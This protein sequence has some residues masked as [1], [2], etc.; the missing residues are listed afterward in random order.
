MLISIGVVAI[1]LLA[2]PSAPPVI[3]RRGFNN[4]NCEAHP[5]A[6]VELQDGGWLMV[7]DSVCWDGSAEYKR[8]VF[9]VVAD[10]NGVERWTRVLGNLGFNYGKYGTQLKD[11]TIIVGGSKSVNDPDAAN[12]GFTYIEKRALWRLDALTGALLSETLFPNEGKLDGLRDGVM[13]VA[14]TTDGTNAIVATGWV[15]GEANW[16]GHN[17]DD[18]PMFLIYNGAAFAMRL[19][20]SPSELA[21]PPSLE[22]EVRLG[23][24]RSFG[25]RAMQ[26]MRI[27]MLPDQ[28]NTLAISAASCSGPYDGDWSVHFSL[29]S[30][31]A[32]TGELLWVRRYPRGTASHPYAMTLS[33]RDDPEPGMVRLPALAVRPT[34]APHA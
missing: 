27:H 25:F 31:R 7:G 21:A 23:L 16:D 20:F 15:G 22:F 26:G 3:Y 19:S 13:C 29:L 8:G 11:G 28:S 1:V 14:P 2:T 24:N 9:V 17:Y 18:E 33:A 30:L 34:L 5:H 32:D 4:S 10:S 12:R 6:G